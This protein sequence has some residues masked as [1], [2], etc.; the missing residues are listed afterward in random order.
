[1]PEGLPR[2][3][4][5]LTRAMVQRAVGLDDSKLL[6]EALGATQGP[7]S[8]YE[9]LAV[10]VELASRLVPTDAIARCQHLR[11]QAC[12]RE[13]FPLAIK[14]DMAQLKAL[15]S[16][17]RFET[18][19]DLSRGLEALVRRYQHPMTYVPEVLHLCVL[20]NRRAKRIPEAKRCLV[21]ALHW[22]HALAL[23]NVPQR[24]RHGFMEDNVVNR[25]L[26]QDAA[27][28]WAE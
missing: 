14:A 15:L 18:A 24:Y 6:E 17:E 7:Q 16:L 12:E 4:R 1:M 19:A 13:Y 26:R 9:R 3:K 8:R 2:G 10:E 5:L 25:R 11:V 27:Q 23:P 22:L 20:A 21:E 28:Q